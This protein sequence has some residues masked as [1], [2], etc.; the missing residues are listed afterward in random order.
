MEQHDT[1]CFRLEVREGSSGLG[2]FA[3]AAAAALTLML[4]AVAWTTEYTFASDCLPPQNSEYVGQFH[5][6]YAAGLIDLRDPIHDRFTTCDPPPGLGAADQFENFGSTVR[7]NISTDGGGTYQPHQIPAQVTVKV[8]NSGPIG[9]GRT[10]FDTEMLQLDLAGGTLPPGVMIRESP[11]KQSLGQTTSRPVSGGYAIDSFFDVFTELSLDGG[12]TWYPSEGAA[13]HM[14]MQ[15]PQPTPM[16][17][18]TW[19]SLKLMYR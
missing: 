17:K 6:M 11:T 16:R 15:G 2:R 18:S 8:H 1:G 4:P 7:C 12:Q 9:A 10:L 19:G 3:L 5:Q 14:T 13:G